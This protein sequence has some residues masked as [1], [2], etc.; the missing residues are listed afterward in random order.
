MHVKKLKFALEQVLFAAH[1]FVLVILLAENSLVIP[2]WVHVVG[3]LHPL[4]LHF[5]IVLLLLAIL[6]LLFPRMLKDPD[7]QLYY[8]HFLLLLGCVFSAITVIAGFFLA[9]EGGGSSAVANHKW[10]G[11]G[12]FWLASLLYW[13]FDKVAERPAVQKTLASLIGILIVVTGHLGA[14]L[15]H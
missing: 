11:L 6:M 3:R 14:S 4:V 12:V 10:T 2:D 5:P 7:D 15:T 9:L 1:V 8:G 13:T